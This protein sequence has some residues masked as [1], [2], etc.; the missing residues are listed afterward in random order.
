MLRRITPRLQLDW[1]DRAVLAAS[2]RRLSD[3]LRKHRLVTPGTALRW[4]QRLV[5][6]NRRYPNQTGRPPV[7]DTVVALIERMAR[8]N[9]TRGHRRI[10]RDSRSRPYG[11]T[12]ASGC[13]GFVLVDQ[14]A[15]DRSTAHRRGTR[16]CDRVF[17]SW[18]R[19]LSGSV[20]SAVVVV[21]R[22]LVQH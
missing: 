4:H 18:W 20:R 22:V 1:T 11:L 5:A 8:E 13:R 12:C 2:V 3:W 14:A 21:G 6:K 17:R 7:D 16:L 10:L 19:E 15:E 9:T